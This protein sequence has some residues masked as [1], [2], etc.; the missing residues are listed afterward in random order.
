MT[1]RVEG[2]EFRA[3]KA[4]LACSRTFLGAL[5]VSGMREM[6]QDEIELKD[7]SA[8][9]VGGVWCSAVEQYNSVVQCDTAV[10]Y[11][12]AVCCAV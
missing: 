11:C 6:E 12:F 3:H 4:V 2:E 10:R 9:E 7:I 8:R 5:M 1:L